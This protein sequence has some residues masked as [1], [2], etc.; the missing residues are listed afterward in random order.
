M[1]GAM[2]FAG[3]ALAA[4]VQL[5]LTGL[6]SQDGVVLVTAWQSPEGFPMARERAAARWTFS[7][8]SGGAVVSVDV[9]PGVWAFTVIHD[10]DDNGALN[11]NWLGMPSEGVG[12]S[13]GRSASRFGPPRFSDA[14]VA[15]DTAGAVVPISIAYLL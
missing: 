4:P 14:V 13:V 15:V 1:I 8:A 3:I 6:R 12:A 10:E 7:A 11:T 9:A 5:R 2:L